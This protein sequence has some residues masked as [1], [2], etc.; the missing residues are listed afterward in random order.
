M[1]M[2]N[3]EGSERGSR[4]SSLSFTQLSKRST[5]KKKKKKNSNETHSCNDINNCRLLFD[6]AWSCLAT[7]FAAIWVSVHPNLPAPNRGPLKAIF[8]RIGMMLVAVI[9][10]ELIVFF[11]ARQLTVARRFAH[12]YGVSLTHGFFF[13]MGGFVSRSDEHP[14]TTLEQLY[15]RDAR[16]G[17]RYRDDIRR[18]RREDIMDKSKGDGLSKGLALFQG[19]WFILQIIARFAQRL[20]VSELEVATLAFAVVNLFTWLLWWHKP[21]DV[22]E[23]I[24]IGPA[25]TTD[26]PLYILP[27]VK[28]SSLCPR[29]DL[30][31]GA[32]NLTPL[33]SIFVREPEVPAIQLQPVSMPVPV[34]HCSPAPGIPQ[35]NARHDLIFDAVFRGPVQGTYTHYDPRIST[36][37]PEF[38]SS[39]EEPAHS[40]FAAMAVGVVF[41][42]IHCAAWSAAFPTTLERILWRVCAVVM[43]AY[44][45]A[46]LIPHGLAALLKRRAHDHVPLT[47]QLVGVGLYSGCRVILLVLVFTTLRRVDQGWLLDVDWTAYIPH[48]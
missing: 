12:R 7:I 42:A 44:P 38:W 43:A 9:A 2:H 22:Q 17:T 33:L 39:H 29:L 23:P 45:A 28:T 47:V 16:L 8:R 40:S 37:V 24:L 5:K 20:P 34:L 4:E 46:L 19:L 26:P 48:L 14:I 25:A 41:G 13:C 35:H 31:L 10:P 30:D 27:A 1:T 36:C 21:L 3:V 6:I 18:I 15:P 32:S 11:A